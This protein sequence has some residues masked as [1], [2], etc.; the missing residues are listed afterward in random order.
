MR[1]GRAI[2]LSL[3]AAAVALMPAC[4]SEPRP[5][6]IYFFEGSLN[7]GEEGFSRALASVTGEPAIAGNRCRILENGA[8]MFPAMLDAIRRAEHS[9][10][11]ETYIFQSDSTGVRFARALEERARAGVRCR[12]LVDAWGSHT[13][14]KELEAEMKKA[15]VEFVRFRPIVLFSKFT[16]R[17][18]RKILVVDGTVGF[19]GGQGFDNRWDGDADSPG[20]WHD[21]AV[22]IEG[23][24]VARLQSVFAENWIDQHRTIPSGHSDYPDLA[25]A[26]ED[27][28]VI[29]KSSFGERGSRTALALDLFLHAARSEVLIENAYFLPND[30]TIELLRKAVERGVRVEV[31]V[32]GRKN[33][34]PFVRRASRALYGKL[35]LAG[36]KIYEYRP[37]MMHAKTMVI[38]GQWSS[39]GSSN[40]DNRSFFL[41]DEANVNVRSR[42]IAEGLEAMFARDK[43]KCDEI[44]YE[45]WNS[46]SLYQKI[47]E[48]FFGLF[49]NQF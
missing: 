20:H 47:V 6:A 29:L 10:N 46:R 30:T 5:Q 21:V 44:T 12:V 19:V 8:E 14:S 48:K 4:S 13:L 35:L 33:N 17:T 32:P 23:P 2:S 16:N 39:I 11:V 40:I 38:D 27:D 22:R 31:I 28:V 34:L 25:P 41:N 43:E 9:I 15:G 7:T 36:V 1:R 3:L 49:Q 26:G 18:H 24:A 45:K 42:P 37:T